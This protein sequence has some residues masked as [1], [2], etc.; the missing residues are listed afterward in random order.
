MYYISEKF[1]ADYVQYLQKKMISTFPDLKPDDIERRFQECLKFLYIS[2][3]IKGGCDV[4]ISS[5]V[6]D[7]WHFMI[8]QTW[9]YKELCSK[10]PGKKFIHHNSN[11]YPRDEEKERTQTDMERFL[12]YVPLYVKYFGPF[13][14]H[15]EQDWPCLGMIKNATDW[16]LDQINDFGRENMDQ[17]GDRIIKIDAEPAWCIQGEIISNSSNAAHMS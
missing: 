16:G 3:I 10:L 13:T 15:V 8:M 17:L 2:S 14:S 7:V 5:E 6:D 4:P 11:D 1:Y 12:T 9:Q